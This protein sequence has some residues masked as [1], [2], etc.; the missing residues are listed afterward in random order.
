MVV[1]SLFTTIAATAAAMPATAAMTT[2]EPDAGTRTVEHAMG[3]TEVP[4]DP[5]RV[6]VLDSSFLDAALALG[7]VPVGATEASDG[8]GMPDYLA[9]EVPDIAV[10]GLTNE[11]NLEAIAALDPDLIFGAKVRHE[12]LYD[13]L[14]GIAP[15][16]FTASSGTNWKDGLA[17]TADALGRADEA[18]ALLE[19]YEARAADVGE[20]VDADGSRASIV[21]F[22]LPDEI[23]LYGPA[24]FS[25][26]VLTDIGFDLGEHDWNQYSMA[27]ISGEQLGLADADVV[28]ATA[29]GGTD[30]AQ[31]ED[32]FSS[33]QPLWDS[34]PAV[35]D[36][37]QHWVADDTWM[38]G[39]GLIGAGLILDD[40]EAIL[41]SES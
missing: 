11:P 17:V 6:V 16:V 26:T 38:T 15:T 32:A 25:G 22:L 24:T 29:Y 23:R 34:V 30:T 18:R 40:V 21:R 14:S 4:A 5:Q 20:R 8:F 1:A 19:D 28:F 2:T 39:I 33:L 7:V 35:A 12:A 37:R 41:V 36:G 27:L 3:I 13:K 31:F 10:V 9:A